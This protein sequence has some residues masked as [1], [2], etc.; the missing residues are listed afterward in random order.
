MFKSKFDGALKG[1][2][3][4]SQTALDALDHELIRARWEVIETKSAATAALQSP[5]EASAAIQESGVGDDD[6]ILMSTVFAADQFETLS[7]NQRDLVRDAVD[8]AKRVVAAGVRLIDGTD[9]ESSNIA[10]LRD[11]AVGRIHG[12][13]DGYVVIIY[14][15]KSSG[16][17]PTNPFGRS[18]PLRKAHVD[19]LTRVAQGQVT[20]LRLGLGAPRRRV[21][22]VR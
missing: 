16:E 10:A 8:D 12:G 4:N 3:K 1:A 18:A 15:L 13:N 20:R 22:H 21:D 2:L 9:A 7:A 6:L 14:D 17:D 11:S 5:A 19:R